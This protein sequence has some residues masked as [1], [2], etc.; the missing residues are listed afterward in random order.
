MHPWFSWIRWLNPVYYSFE[1]LMANE[2]TGLEL[3]C[4]Q[5]Q[6]VP[7]G[8]GYTGVSQG[9]AI[10]GAQPG[11]TMLSGT[12]WVN[13]ALKFFHSHI[14]RNFGIVVAIWIFFLAMCMVTIERLPAAGSNKAI[15]LYKRGGGGKFIRAANERGTSPRDEEE[16]S[17]ETQ[18]NEKA[19]RGESQDASVEKVQGGNT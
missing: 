2:L 13:Q 12:A 1:A 14:W 10:T 15:L 18:T 5:P 8:Q 3:E 6:L 7:Y 19:Q 4:I 11:S 17:A 16:G 9:C